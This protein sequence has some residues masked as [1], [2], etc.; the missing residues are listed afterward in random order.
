MEWGLVPLLFLLQNCHSGHH[1]HHWHS[2]MIEDWSLAPQDR[3]VLLLLPLLLW[4]SFCYHDLVEWTT[5]RRMEKAERISLNEHKE[6]RR[7]TQ[8]KCRGTRTG[9]GRRNERKGNPTSNE[10][11]KRRI[12]ILKKREK[13][14]RRSEEE[15][16]RKNWKFET[17][18]KSAR[19]RGKR[20]RRGSRNRPRWWW[21]RKKK[22][23]EGT[24]R[25]NWNEEDLRRKN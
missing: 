20:G 21:S 17:R 4:S 16:R 24:R 6:R 22:S 9:R 14:K 3:V 1:H 18:A 23:M 12:M 8:W 19:E 2:C 25:T 15:T 11:K 10:Q 5:G 7:S 13:K